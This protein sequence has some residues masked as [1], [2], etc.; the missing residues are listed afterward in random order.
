MK[1]L[2]IDP[3]IKNIGICLLDKD[4]GIVLWK[5]LC[6]TENKS[7]IL[8]VLTEKLLLLL[9]EIFDNTI[10]IDD[11][12]IEN[13]P[14]KANNQIK[15]ISVEIYTFF[16]MLKLMHGNIKNVRFI[17]AQNKLKDYYSKNLTYLER[18]KLSVTI[19]KRYIETYYKDNLEWF[20]S[21]KKKDD[22]SDAFLYCINHISLKDPLDC[23]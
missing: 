4:K 6:I 19:T 3:G 14:S 18:K 15:I 22:L 21:N 1:V 23:V 5:N 7:D 2:A 8:N 16:N 17:S 12:L 9:M 11:V 10:E 20:N 13:Q